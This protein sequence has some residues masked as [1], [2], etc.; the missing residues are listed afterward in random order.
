MSL[1]PPPPGWNLLQLAAQATSSPEAVKHLAT[2]MNAL[3]NQQETLEQ[4]ECLLAHSPVGLAMFDREMR[5][6]AA[7]QRWVKDHDLEG[8]KWRGRLV[9]EL[10]PDVPERW[11]EIRRRA[12]SGETLG[13]E[14]DQVP[15]SD[16]SVVVVRWKIEPW[17]D[18]QGRIGGVVLSSEILRGEF[19]SA[20]PP[21]ID[22]A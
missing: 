6:L 12:L 21:H 20:H 16:G 5:Y 15:C 1:T 18:R 3:L 4:L 10:L 17:K 8:I 2:Q 19:R 11:K 22:A 9:D 13:D 7:N 14:A